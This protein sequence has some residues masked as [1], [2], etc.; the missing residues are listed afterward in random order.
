MSDAADHP[1]LTDNSQT[2]NLLIQQPALPKYRVP[3]FR[4]LASRPGIRLKVVYSDAFREM[5]NF[6][7]E[8]FQA[9]RVPLWRW[10]LGRQHMLWS[11]AQW[12]YARRCR[13]G[14]LILSW[15]LHYATLAPALLRARYNGVP[16]ILWGHGYSKTERLW[17]RWPREQ[18]ARLATALLFYN[19]TTAA[20]FI[21]HGWDPRRVF[22]ALN[23]LDQTPIQAARKAW[24]D[25]PD[26]LQAFRRDNDL[27]DGP[28]VLFVSRLDPDD[29]VDMLLEAAVKLSGAYPALK[30]VI[31]GSGP[32]EQRLR[33][34]ADRL[35]I[36]SRVRF[37]GAIYDE[38]RL[39]PWFLSADVFC[40]PA[41]IGLSV[42]HAF[43]Y[44]LPVVTSNAIE[45]HNPEIEAV[46]H[47]V[48]G[49]MYRDGDV[50]AMA[51][52]LRRIIDD[53]ELRSR[54]SQAA[55]ET[56]LSRFTLKN[57][58]DGMEA[59]VRYCAAQIRA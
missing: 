12:Q 13:G 56:V 52:A 58:V 10:N 17:R 7:P 27:I 45:T 48:N 16:T 40:Y 5:P 35:G 9:E 29:R 32:D 26:K 53:R 1:S 54:M 57:M 50:S 6:E 4:E 51:D 11:W 14:V 49:L 24:L 15:D 41:N 43:G 30:V 2:I 37:V 36:S 21:A 46:Q 44:G 18:V 55:L 3:V 22:V 42:L 20:R 8:G 31:I 39:A 34:L 33:T 38:N 19:H 23:S 25:D 47:E 28:I 59:A